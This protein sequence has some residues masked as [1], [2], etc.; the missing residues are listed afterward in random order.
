MTLRHHLCIFFMSYLC[1]LNIASAETEKT[2]E[3]P[4]KFS[5]YL[6][7]SYNYLV[8]SNQF[9][10]FTLNRAFDIEQDGFTLQQAAATLAYQPEKGFGAFANVILGRDANI[11]APY[12]WD[13][14]IGSQ[15]LAFVAPD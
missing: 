4:L 11:I 13:P 9:T 12:G 3:N 6:D 14:Y 7:T 2:P 1:F 5:G 8:R 10:S 15:T